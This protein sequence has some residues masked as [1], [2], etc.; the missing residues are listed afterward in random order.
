MKR[1]IGTLLFAVM[2]H[3]VLAQGV[4]FM[5][6][7]FAAAQS[8]AAR[9]NKI[10]FVEVYLNGCPHCA[11]IAPVLQEK[12]V[13]DFYNANFVSLKLEANSNDSKFLQQQKNI[14]YPDF[15]Q[16][17]FFDISGKLIHQ[18]SPSEMPSRPQFI[19]EAIK[20]GRNAL[21]P[22]QRSSNYDSRWAAG[23]RNIAFLVN[24]A[25]Y[26]K[27]VKNDARLEEING[28]FGQMFKLKTDLEHEIGFYVIK[29]FM[30]DAHNPMA[31]YFLAN[32][33]NY[34]TKFPAKDVQEAV[35][36]I[37]YWSMYGKKSATFKAN[38][39]ESFKSSMIKVGVPAKDATNRTLLKTLEADFRERQTARATQRLN[40]QI[41]T[42]PLVFADYAYFVK[43]FNDNATDA[44]YAPSNIQWCNNALKLVKA[45]ERNK[46]EVA[47]IYYEQSV[48][49]HKMGKKVEG[50][51]AAQEALKIAQAARIDTQK[52][53][54]QAGK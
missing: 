12:K 20:H 22:K 26:I 45:N 53:T 51:K 21:D 54:T 7:G 18:A 36:G 49:Y 3:G 6:G 32:L 23:E 10:L 17:L 39:I 30:N 43:Y 14:T 8:A 9:S 5:E 19:E 29:N 38:E 1:F 11:A 13:G 41:T 46:K 28:Q 40:T 52:Y 42:S 37:T 2:A 47:D 34:Q 24:Y 48:A 35:E 33:K 50:K 27:T 31:K 4:G 16:F 15:P 44:T 25:K